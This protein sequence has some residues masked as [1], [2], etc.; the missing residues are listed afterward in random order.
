ML[1]RAIMSWCHNLQHHFMRLLSLLTWPSSA[2]RA[3]SLCSKWEAPIYWQVRAL[4]FSTYRGPPI[5]PSSIVFLTIMGSWPNGMKLSSTTLL[6]QC[7]ACLSAWS[8]SPRAS[9]GQ[10]VTAWAS[11]YGDRVARRPTPGGIHRTIDKKRLS[12]NFMPF[13]SCSILVIQGR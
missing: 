13:G 3:A 12:P 10:R 5:W 6:Y 7:L 9:L 1:R 8:G 4:A 2:S 11:I